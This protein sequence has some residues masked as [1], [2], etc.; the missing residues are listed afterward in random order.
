MTGSGKDGLRAIGK[1]FASSKYLSQ[2]D[3][4]RNNNVGN[5]GIASLVMAAKERAG[6]ATVAFP[7]LEKLILSECNIGPS[8][9]QSLAEVFSGADAN[10]CKLIYL[11]I[12]SNPIGS[13]GCE[14]LA[15]LIAM[16][17]KGSILSCLYISQCSIGNEGVK[18]LSNAA[19]S[20]SCI[21][22]TILDLS[23]N[24]IT[25]DGA[26]VF[27]ESLVGSWPSLVEL[28]LANND[29]GS[30]GVTSVMESLR[31][32]RVWATNDADMTKNQ[33]LQNLDLTCTGC[34]KEGAIAALNSI[35]LTTLRLFNNRLGSEGFRSCSTL[36]RGG[37]IS[38]ESLDLGGNNADE[39]SVVV[40]LN[41]IADKVDDGIASKLAVLEIGGNKFGAKAMEAL[42][43]LKQVWPRLDVAHDKPIDE[44]DED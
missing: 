38:I 42:T 9:M 29:L 39:E 20:N 8:G 36:L 17:E 34:E 41:A 22:L 12:S 14:T 18:L 23:E 32:R 2:I 4:S 43:Q 21:G 6:N 11:A 35:C 7:S 13:E 37:H 3:L 10:R 31:T 1:T 16:P 27:A 30:V 44:A 40:L 24:S 19:T 26:R 5:E 25:S 15:R 33:S 28:K